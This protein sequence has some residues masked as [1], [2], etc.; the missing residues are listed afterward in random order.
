MLK[1]LRAQAGVSSFLSRH[2]SNPK[3][4]KAELKL[5]VRTA[6]LHLAPADMSGFEVCPGRSPG[7]TAACLHFAGNPLAQSQKDRSRIA[8]TRFFFHHRREF[9]RALQR[10]IQNHAATARRRGLAPAV[11]LNGTSDLPWER[12]R[13]DFGTLMET[14]PEISF[15]DYTAVIQRLRAPLP[16]NYN[17][18]FSLK[19]NNLPEALE[20]LE[21]G[22]NV[23]AV[24]D[25]LP[26]RYFGRPVIDGDEHDYRP[27]DPANVIVGLRAKGTKARS[28]ASGFVSR[29]EQAIIRLA[30]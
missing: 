17:L 20:A 6:V 22:F 13:G 15:Y 25:A 3:I 29:S 23:A 11:R 19:E 7:C 2:N 9:M 4:A 12:V 28:D 26:E 18:T 24:F 14:F 5:G 8:R 16:A 21:L 10:E 1:A 27:S 30:A